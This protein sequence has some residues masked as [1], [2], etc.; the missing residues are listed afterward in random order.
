MVYF[1]RY[2][3]RAPIASIVFSTFVFLLLSWLGSFSFAI[4]GA[5][6]LVLIPLSVLGL[7]QWKVTNSWRYS[8]RLLLGI[9]ALPL[10]VVHIIDSEATMAALPV[11]FIIFTV[12]LAC[13]LKLPS[14][15]RVIVVLPSSVLVFVFLQL[16]FYPAWLQKI[17]FNRWT[18]E[19]EDPV[20]IEGEF[21]DEQGHTIVLPMK[22]KQWVVEFW[23]STC[24]NCYAEMPAFEELRKQ[25]ETESLQFISIRKPI[26]YDRRVRER[27][28]AVEREFGSNAWVAIDS[29]WAEQHGIGAFPSYAIIDQEGRMTHHGTFDRIAQALSNAFP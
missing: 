7:Q 15:P 29:S 17:D 27:I 26:Q 22:G 1:Q 14:W 25:Y 16:W 5:L 20:I 28:Q 10:V 23:F 9:Q 24:A 12:S 11:S 18:A 21:L 8:S 2:R 3:W 4:K 19:V 13:A 6:A